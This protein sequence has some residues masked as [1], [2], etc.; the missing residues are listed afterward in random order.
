MQSP[1]KSSNDG[2]RSRKAGQRKNKQVE[3]Q[4]YEA[5]NVNHLRFN[6]GNNGGTVFV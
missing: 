3:E 5:R 6:E 4:G 1:T 2:P